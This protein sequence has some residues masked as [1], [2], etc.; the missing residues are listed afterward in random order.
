[1]HDRAGGIAADALPRI[2][3][4]FYTTKDVGEGS[5]LG[6][7][8][9]FGIITELGGTITAESEGGESRFTILLPAADAPRAMTEREPR[10]EPVRLPE[11][12]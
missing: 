3:M 11:S 4:P 2:F 7:S 9:C 12:P 5:G 8:V 1:V 10:R 6:L